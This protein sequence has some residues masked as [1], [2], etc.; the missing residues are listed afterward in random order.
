MTTIYDIAKKVGCAPSTVSKYITKHGYVSRA[1]GERIATAMRE[2]DYHY[3]GLARA[4]STS[5]C[6]RVGVIV[7]FLDHPYFQGLVNAISEALAKAGKEVVIFPT[8]YSI[9]NEHRAL[10]E[11]THHLVEGLIVTSHALPRQEICQY[12]AAGP[13][14][15]CETVTG[16]ATKAVNIDR[17]SAM[18]DLFQTLKQQQ[19]T[20]IGFLFIRHPEH[21][22]TTTEILA[23]YQQ[24]FNCW[25][26]PTLLNYHCRSFADGQKATKQLLTAR[27]AV[28]ALLTESDI[29]AAGAQQVIKQQAK[30]VIIIGQ[31]NHLLSSLLHFSSIDQHLSEIGQQAVDLVLNRATDPEKEI[32]FNFIWRD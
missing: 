25:P 26:D 17:S 16:S 27:P 20:R 10:D 13:I 21:S 30:P 24:V 9:A 14:V 2:M 12:Q 15:F 18:R 29:T 28:Q 32:K 5:T 22:V 11:L 4:L 1:L 31:G 7:P 8:R 19:L 3:N 6:N 23:A